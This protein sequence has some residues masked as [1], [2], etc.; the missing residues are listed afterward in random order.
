MKLTDLITV[1][2]KCKDLILKLEPQ[3][4]LSSQGSH[5]DE[6][7]NNLSDSDAHLLTIRSK[8]NESLP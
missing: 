4:L 2:W 7:I 1:I 5:F 3:S 6:L 8:V